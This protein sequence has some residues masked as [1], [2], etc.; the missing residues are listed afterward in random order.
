M[1]ATG[2]VGQVGLGV[3][4]QLYAG[5][6]LKAGPLLAFDV[7]AGRLAEAATRGATPRA[8]AA[9]VASGSDLV[10]LSLPSPEAVRA[11]MTGPDGLLAGVRGRAV[12]LDTSTVDPGT[13]REMYERA[14]ASGARYLDAPVSGG[15]P[16]GAGTDGARAATIS[17]MVGGDRDAF[18]DAEGVMRLLGQRWFYLGPSGSGSTV[19][20]ISNLMAGLHNLVAAEAFVLAAAAGFS[21]E[22]LFEVFDGTDA[23]SYWLTDYFAPRIRRRDFEPGFSVDLQYKDHRLAAELAQQLKVPALLNGLAVQMYQMLRAQGLGGKDL[24]E[25][26]NEFGRMAGVDIYEPGTP[27]P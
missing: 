10:V 7:D 6:L 11:V 20:L 1:G 27:R 12:I 13:S 8:S 5:H 23:K 2:Q 21:P 18:E 9:E 19:K 22:T 16:G 14:G 15:A 3:I 26:V 4:G 17:F 24:V 25:A